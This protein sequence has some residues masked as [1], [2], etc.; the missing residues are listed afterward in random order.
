MS[1]VKGRALVI[2]AVL[3]FLGS[4][5]AR[6]ALE[7]L[8]VAVAPARTLELV[9]D[10]DLAEWEDVPAVSLDSSSFLLTEAA[11]YSGRA[12]IGGA[13]QFVW[14]TLYIYVAGRFADDSL[15]AG[16]AWTSDRINLVFDFHNDNNPLSYDGRAPDASSWQPDDQWV[17][18]HIV[19]D[20]ESPFPVMRLGSDYHGPIEGG[21]L[22][23]EAVEGGWTFEMRV[24]W[25]EL[26]EA[27]PFVG[28]VFGLQI[29]VS[30][31]DGGGRLTEIMWSDR[32]SYSSDAGLSWELW[33]MGR[34]VLTGAPLR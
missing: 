3:L 4:T 23:S 32:W 12:D 13:I 1:R 24:P 20:G 11:L 26:P 29:F 15:A 34:L 25:A 31:G 21:A 22:A 33:K 14:D 10:G 28:A 17:Y 18:A 2:G 19:G 7:S 16:A 9:I 30:D 6:P 8:A 5:V 27:R